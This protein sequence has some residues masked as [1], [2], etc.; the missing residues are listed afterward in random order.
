MGFFDIFE[1]KYFVFFFFTLKW[2]THKLSTIRNLRQKWPTKITTLYILFKNKSNW[3]NTI[4]VFMAADHEHEPF[5]W[6]LVYETFLLLFVLYCITYFWGQI[7]YHLKLFIHPW[8]A[9]TKKIIVPSNWTKKKV[10]FIFSPC[11]WLTENQLTKKR[12]RYS[13]KKQAGKDNYY[14]LK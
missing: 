14:F 5:L 3:D 12:K 11:P 10:F 4:L 2:G 8:L 6:L 13:I 1:I 9:T 7:L